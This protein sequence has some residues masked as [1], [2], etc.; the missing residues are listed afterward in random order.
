M[1]E[2]PLVYMSTESA[3]K[4]AA[5]ARAMERAGVP[6]RVEGAKVDSG[7]N[8]Q[9]MTMEETYEGAMNRHQALRALGRAADYYATVESGLHRVHEA[10]DIYGCNVVIIETSNGEMRVG[11]ALDVAFPQEMLDKVPSVYPD[12]GVLVQEEYGAAEKDPYPYFTHGRL[13]RRETIENAVYNV[14]IQLEEKQ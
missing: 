1:T 12:L 14:A 11:F 6:V 5:V 2:R 3:L 9:P 7:V 10:H 13:T 4:H 8:E